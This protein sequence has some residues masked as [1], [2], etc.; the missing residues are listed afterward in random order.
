MA[1]LARHL[2]SRLPPGACQLPPTTRWSISR[3]FSAACRRPRE[4]ARPT[5]SKTLVIG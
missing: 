5:P 3:T 1:S 4:A 2:P